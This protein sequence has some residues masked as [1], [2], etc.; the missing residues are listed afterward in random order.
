MIPTVT[1]DHAV[2]RIM[3]TPEPAAD[4]Q[5]SA[6]PRSELDRFDGKKVAVCG[7]VRALMPS[8]GPGLIA[9]C[10]TDVTGVQEERLAGEEGGS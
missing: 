8:R 6:R 5:R 7:I 10:L 4:D 3:G 2:R 1:R 9:S